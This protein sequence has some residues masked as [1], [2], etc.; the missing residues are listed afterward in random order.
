MRLRLLVATG[1]GVAALATPASAVVPAVDCHGVAFSD[2]AGDQSLVSSNNTI[3][4]PTVAIDL[5]DVYLTGSGINEKVNIQVTALTAWNNTEYSFRWDDPV[6]FGYYYELVGSFLGTNTA[7]DRVG[8]GYLYHRSFSGSTISL[9]GHATAAAF[10]GAVVNGVEQPGV[11]QL[12]LPPQD[13]PTGYPTTISG[14]QAHATQYEFNV[15][16][17]VSVRNDS[18]AAASAWS[19]PC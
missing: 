19:Q 1:I 11:I 16:T 9:N 14:M 18:A 10:H 2:A 7:A 17:D 3:L 4:R 8:D 12:G 6:N 5:R 15:L 13:G